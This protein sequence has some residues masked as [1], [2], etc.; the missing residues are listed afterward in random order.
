M[1]AE[2]RRLAKWAEVF[3]NESGK[4]SFEDEWVAT[5]VNLKI[6]VNRVQLVSFACSPVDCEDLAIGF[7]FT[8]GIISSIE[9]IDH[10][11]F[12][13]DD[14]QI[15]LIL[16]ETNAK[17][18]ENWNKERTLS[19]GCAQGVISNLEF[20]RKSLVP[21]S[22]KIN[23]GVTSIARL[24]EHLKN[25]SS[26]YEK[27]G[28]IHLVALFNTDRTAIMREDIGRHNAVDKVIGAALQCKINFDN[29]IMSCT[30][31]LSSDMIL[32]AAKAR[33]PIIVSRTAPTS[34]AVN[35]AEDSGI[36]L[37]G[38]ARGRRLNIYTHIDRIIFSEEQNELLNPELFKE[39]KTTHS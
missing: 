36:T 22:Q 28:C 32:K 4:I 6:I 29:T 38:F 26:W 12:N 33:I 15:E 7:L 25:N 35:I 13:R 16:S 20:R 9:D 14:N 31:R 19:S 1:I 39:A 3:Q 2:K 37:I 27:T 17:T 30:G 10:V 11:I 23:Q 18:I 8:E 34:L 5:E 24:F 21:I